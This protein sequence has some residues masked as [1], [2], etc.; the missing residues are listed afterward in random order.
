M[1]KTNILWRKRP[2]VEYDLRIEI[3]LFP[4]EQDDKSGDAN[5]VITESLLGTHR[6]ELY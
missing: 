4:I 3:I 2:N 1:K 6:N 5:G